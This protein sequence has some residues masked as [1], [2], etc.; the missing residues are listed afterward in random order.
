M[1]LY[2]GSE[3]IIERPFFGGGKRHNDYGYGFYCTE[4]PDV[5]RE[6]AVNADH[7][8]YLNC[9]EFDFEGL[10]VLD[11]NERNILTWLSV[12]MQNRTFAVDTA[13]AAEARMYLIYNFGI[14]Y[15]GYDVIK[16]YRA[17]DSYFSFAQDFINNVISLEQLRTAMHLGGLG[18]QIVL[19]SKKSF[20]R[21]D[22]KDSE[23]VPRDIWLPKREERDRKAREAYFSMNRESYV[24]NAIYIS[25]I[26]DEEMKTDD[27][28]LQ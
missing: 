21:I 8:G 7:N 24:R 13:L 2:H 9:Y 18:N 26:I 6:W 27:P 28:R 5:A 17:D 16:G 20:E 1:V 23:A 4:F 12:L 15:E 11:L 19:K 3:K 14:D 22:F 10:S 25:K